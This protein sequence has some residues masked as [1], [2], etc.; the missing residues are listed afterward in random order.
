MPILDTVEQVSLQ[1]ILYLTDFSEA[2]QA[3]VPFVDTLSRQY[4]SKLFV[5]HVLKPDP[6]ICMAPEYA[7]AVNAGLAQQASDKMEELSS[8]FV[9]APY[10]ATVKNG[11][12]VWQIVRDYIERFHIDLVCVGSHGRSGLQRVWLGSVAEE[13]FR[14]SR[15]PVLTVGPLVTRQKSEKRLQ[16]ILFATDLRAQSSEPLKYAVSIARQ[17]H[18]RL[19]LLHVINKCGRREWTQPG[20]GA[21][22]DSPTRKTSS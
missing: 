12:D 1:N 4:G 7:D 18:S 5:L 6:Y 3:A 20:L 14:R 16:S 21:R 2:S 9:L 15:V 13:V 19:V 10:Q 8:R 11:P 22:S 17:N